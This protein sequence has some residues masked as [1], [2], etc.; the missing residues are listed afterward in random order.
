M[1]FYLAAMFQQID[2]MRH[3]ADALKEAGH[4]CTARWVYGGEEGLSLPDIARIDLEDIDRADALVLFSFPRG[5]ILPA[6]G[7]RHVEFGYALAR[8]KALIIVGPYENVFQEHPLV[9]RF[10]TYEEFLQWL[11]TSTTS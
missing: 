11:T 6:G 3:C 9:R 10:G 1:R 4:E 5:M 8:E 2:Y 7:G